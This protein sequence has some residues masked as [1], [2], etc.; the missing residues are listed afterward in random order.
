MDLTVLAKRRANELA[1]LIADG[2]ERIG[3]TGA[4]GTGKS[5]TAKTVGVDPTIHADDV[6]VLPDGRKRA[7]DEIGPA[8]CDLCPSGKMLVEGTEVPQALR[9]GLKVDVLY[10]LTEPCEHQEPAHL[11]L[12][13]S[14]LTVLKQVTE[15]NTGLRII[16]EGEAQN[17][18]NSV[19]SL[20]SSNWEDTSQGGIKLK[21]VELSKADVFPYARNGAVVYEYRSPDGLKDPAA[22][23]TLEGATVTLSS[24]TFVT[25]DNFKPLVVGHVQNVQWDEERQSLIGDVVINDRETV[26]RVKRGE[27]CEVSCGYA[28]R[29]IAKL[30]QAP[31]GKR[32]ERVQTEFV[33]NHL[34]LGPAGWS[35][36]GTAFTLDAD[37]IP[38]EG[39]DKPMFKAAPKTA[40]ADA[41]ANAPVSELAPEEKKAEA[42]ADATPT[43][44]QAPT[45]TGPD[46]AV[47]QQLAAAFPEIQAMLADYRVYKESQAQEQAEE[48]SIP[49]QQTIDAKDIDALVAETV[50]LHKEASAVMGASYVTAGKN[51]RQIQTDVVLS[52]DSKFAIP[53]DNAALDAAYRMSLTALQERSKLS[54]SNSGAERM[55]TELVTVSTDAATPQRAPVMDR[56]YDIN[57]RKRN[58]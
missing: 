5:F 52:A 51:K 13:A 4:P 24:H 35:R 37:D 2:C 8:V 50:A 18:L 19:V 54:A 6:L 7:W 10:I 21:G 1:A 20:D 32:F 22:I 41:P 36:Q 40:S 47:L 53:A 57:R 12:W 9:A 23:A 58:K 43:P 42:S 14:M 11:H 31:S 27:L 17:A 49:E 34:A 45:Q 26:D 25:A 55:R 16:Y 46:P 39:E 28:N 3:I 30:G 38:P 15:S 44:E 33:F 48:I 29:F 56:V